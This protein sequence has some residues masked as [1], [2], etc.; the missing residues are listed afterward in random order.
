M[1]LDGGGQLIGTF[2]PEKCLVEDENSYSGIDEV[3]S[4]EKL[5]EYIGAEKTTN[6]KPEEGYVKFAVLIK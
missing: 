5:F 2:W 6:D 4:F 3:K 1:I